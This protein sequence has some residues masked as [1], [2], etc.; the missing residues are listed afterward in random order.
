MTTFLKFLAMAVVW[1]VLYFCSY[2]WNIKH[3][4]YCS[5]EPTEDTTAAVT[6]AAT[7]SPADE[8]VLYS[9]LGLNEVLKGNAWDADLQR[10][11]AK[12][13]EDPQQALE[14]TGLYYAGEAVP[15]TSDAAD[16][17][18]FRAGQIRD[19]L[20]A[21]GIPTGNIRLLSDEID[22][23][24][25]AEGDFFEVGDFAWGRMA[26]A[27]N[28]NAPEMVTPDVRNDDAKFD[29][30]RKIRFPFNKSTRD[31]GNDIET[32]LKA[33]ANRVKET[34]ETIGIV[35]HTDNVDD[36]PYNMKLGQS[37]ADFV[38]DRLVQ[39]GVDRN[40]ITTASN[41][42]NSPESTNATAEGRRINRR[43]VVTLNQAQ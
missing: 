31:L 35:G 27:A 40:K 8:Y 15:S 38:R 6:P 39:Y 23:P 11:F 4:A 13:N 41:G 37:R 20:V 28:P 25:P 26:D 34:G 2:H 5:D 21:K 29:K 30:P 24:Q 17:G 18:L 1:A 7:A 22:G 36:E 3:E 14:I 12:Y 19:L 32:Y 42:E 10:L 9:S 43:A 33:L 16:M